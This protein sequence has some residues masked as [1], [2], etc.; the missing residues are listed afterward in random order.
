MDRHVSVRFYEI[1]YPNDGS[2]RVEAI[3]NNLAG[4][5]KRDREAGLD[6]GEVVLRLEHLEE[7]D[8]L[9]LGDITRVQSR[10]LPGHVVDDDVAR[11]P[12]DQIG[13]SSIFLFDPATGCLAL[14]FNMSMGVGRFCKYLRAISHGA[15][16]QYFPYLKRDTLDRFRN[17]TP[18]K[19]RL[20]VARVRNFR[21]I[22]QG[23][24]DFEE[25]LEGWSDLFEAPSIEVV[26]ATRGEGRQL[27]GAEVWNTI[28]RWLGFRNEIEGIK[29]I[30]ATT[31]ESDRAFNFIKDLLFNETILELPDND[32]I[33]SR[34]VRAAYV[35]QCYGEHRDYIRRIAG[36]A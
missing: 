7:R 35:R 25:A 27:D 36:E 2:A 8:G 22:P 13:H 6:N 32:P 4:L 26:M 10:N 3:L 34:R 29:N 15:D 23:K 9:I 20:K 33:E 18:V 19:L 28:R 17:E 1:E 12:V 16:F 21:D 30:E 24:T 14:Q 5:P 11:L 31:I